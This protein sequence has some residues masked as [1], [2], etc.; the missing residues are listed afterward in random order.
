MLTPPITVAVQY[1]L[2]YTDP[3]EENGDEN[4]LYLS[5]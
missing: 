3:S 1:R 5:G 4:T 2:C